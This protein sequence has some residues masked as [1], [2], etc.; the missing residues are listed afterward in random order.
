MHLG[1]AWRIELQLLPELVLLTVPNIP[2][3]FYTKIRLSTPGSKFSCINLGSKRSGWPNVPVLNV[4][5]TAEQYVYAIP[6]ACGDD[7]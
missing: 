4:L 7:G 6:P 2:E 3:Y 5:L 1:W